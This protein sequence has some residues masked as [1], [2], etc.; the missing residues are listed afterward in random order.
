MIANQTEDQNEPLSILLIEVET[1]QNSDR[2]AFDVTKQEHIEE[3]IA[4]IVQ[5]L[6]IK[7]ERKSPKKEEE[8]KVNLRKTN[9]LKKSQTIWSHSILKRMFTSVWTM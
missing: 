9:H 2:D 7:V 8:I 5:E 6:Q 3:N 1:P 4:R